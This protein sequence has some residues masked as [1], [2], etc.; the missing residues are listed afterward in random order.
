MPEPGAPTL[1]QTREFLFEER[2]QADVRAEGQIEHPE[3]RDVLWNGLM[4][5]D[6]LGAEWA[7]DGHGDMRAPN[8]M[9]YGWRANAASIKAPTLVMLGEF[10]N[11]QKRR[12]SW[13]GLKS[14]EHKAFVR[15]GAAS[16]FV[17]FEYA[18]RALHRHGLE[19]LASGTVGGARF[20]EFHSDRDGA[21]SPLHVGGRSG[22][23]SFTL[24]NDQ[25]A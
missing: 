20:G 14:T 19:W 3:I 25:I 17:M 11:Y 9:N 15:I 6:G 8:R 5:E 4:Q 24:V 22:P 18:R 12:D 13:R 7:A 1:L 21:L 2:W 16:H 10:D 23:A